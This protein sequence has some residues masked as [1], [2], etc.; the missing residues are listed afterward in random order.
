MWLKLHKLQAIAFRDLVPYNLWVSLIASRFRGHMSG[1]ANVTN[2][3]YWNW[4]QLCIVISHIRSSSGVAVGSHGEIL[5]EW[6]ATLSGSETPLD[7]IFQVNGVLPAL[8]EQFSQSLLDLFHDVFTSISPSLW[9]HILQVRHP[10]LGF[11]VSLWWADVQRTA[12]MERVTSPLWNMSLNALSS[13]AASNAGILNTVQQPLDHTAFA[14]KPS[15][16]CRRCGRL[17]HW[18]KDCKS[19][20][21]QHFDNRAT[22]DNSFQDRAVRRPRKFDSSRFRGKGCSVFI[23]RDDDD[24]AE[25]E[26]RSSSSDDDDTEYPISDG[27]K[28][29]FS[30]EENAN[31]AYWVT[32]GKHVSDPGA[33]VR[34]EGGHV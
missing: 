5:R 33:A 19:S 17:G 28:P 14:V 10:Y 13:N 22:R 2:R 9:H 11:S 8:P 16:R 12:L 4:V 25:T 29:V 26:L 21:R 23:T 15:D 24:G 31:K 27:D 1:L 7:I 6:K 3:Y 32:L 30:D 20:S 18:K 34:A